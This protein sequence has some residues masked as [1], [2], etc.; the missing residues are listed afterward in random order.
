[1]QQ[2]VMVANVWG[3]PSQMEE[4][5]STLR[6]AMRVRT[7]VT[8]VTMTESSDP[9]LLA[10]RFERQ[11]KELKQELA[12]RDTLRW[13]GLVGGPGGGL[14]LNPGVGVHSGAGACTLM[15]GAGGGPETCVRGVGPVCAGAGAWGWKP[16]V[17][18]W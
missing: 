6:F 15:W 7:L 16:S 12:L 2:T 1:M 18:L 10:K 13:G 14:A 17:G 8:D 5:L 4:T 9:L 3:E 11:I